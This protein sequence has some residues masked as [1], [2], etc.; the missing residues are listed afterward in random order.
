MA[1]YEPTRA[2]WYGRRASNPSTLGLPAGAWWYRTDIHCWKWFDGTTINDLPIK[3]ETVTE[4]FYIPTGGGSDHKNMSVSVLGNIIFVIH[5]DVIDV[6]PSQAD[7]Y[8]P[9]HWDVD[10]LTIGVTVGAASS[11]AG[12]T[13][14]VEALFFGCRP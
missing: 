14:T 2:Q 11:T 6:K 12:T 1:S 5:V 8:T 9:I 10:T 4:Y 7:V 3:D 13:I